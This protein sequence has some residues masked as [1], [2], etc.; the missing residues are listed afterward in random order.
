MIPPESSVHYKEYENERMQI[1]FHLSSCGASNS[2]DSFGF[3]GDDDCE[4]KDYDY[5]KCNYVHD[6]SIFNFVALNN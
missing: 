2:Q 1:S 4:L 3:L 5:E 6:D